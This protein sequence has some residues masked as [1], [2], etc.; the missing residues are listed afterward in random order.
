M[1]KVSE[2]GNIFANL[3]DK[4]PAKRAGNEDDVVGTIIFLASKAGV[5]IKIGLLPVLKPHQDYV[6][7]QNICMDGG[8]ILVAN[9]QE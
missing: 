8:R 1:N 5:C 6:H 2:S 4:V 3:F 9:G 7:G